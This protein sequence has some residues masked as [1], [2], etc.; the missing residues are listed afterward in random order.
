MPKRGLSIVAVEAPMERIPPCI[1]YAAT[2]GGLAKGYEAMR[3]LDQ[4][5]V[6]K[7]DAFTQPA[8]A[9]GA[10]AARCARVPAAN[11]R[12]GRAL[13]AA[14]PGDARRPAAHERCRRRAPGID[15]GRSEER[16]V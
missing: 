9:R 3:R 14:R 16:R 2:A 13:G 4:S 5:F 8:C 1:G 7:V 12:R 15:P 10:L 6:C 11:P